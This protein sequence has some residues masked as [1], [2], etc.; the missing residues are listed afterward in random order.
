M[1]ENVM[2]FPN[3]AQLFSE[4]QRYL[5]GGVS[6]SMRAA[7]K[8]MPLFFSSG[9]GSRITDVDG[10]Q[11]IDYTL[12]WGPLILGHSH[13]AI[14]SAV[15]KQ[16]QL[17][18]TLGAQ[19]ELEILVAQ[20]ICEMVPCAELVAFNNSG[21]EAVQAA[22]RLARA[23]TGKR[24]II[25][26]EGHYHGWLDNIAAG[27]RLNPAEGLRE[28]ATQGSGNQYA[29]DTIILPW[30]DLQALEM[31]VQQQGNEIAA[32]IMEPILCNTSCLLPTSEYLRD[33]RK[34]ATQS[35]VVL[36][37]DEVI[38]GF[39]AALGGAQQ[40]FDVKPDLATFGKAVAGGFTLSVVAGR[41]DIMDLISQGKIMHAGTFNGNPIC[42]AAADATLN[43]LSAKQGAALQ[44]IRK[45]GDLLMNGIRSLAES[46]GVPL[47]INGISSSFHLSF[48]TRSKMQNF[49]DSLDADM[50]IRDQ[51]LEWMLLEGIY[52]MP[53]GRWYVSAAHTEEDVGRTLEA[54]DRVLSTRL[55]KLISPHS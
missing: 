22:F 3:S 33:A 44:H 18:Q 4:A 31:A 6:S 16:L 26:F 15:G 30:N 49:R 34:L 51:F 36:I 10:N 54:V 25:R 43:V 32:I 24:K 27:Y 50:S 28:S 53:D 2:R 55:A 39:R 41:W 7:A 23:F 8:P 48:T 37:F 5:A 1:T 35:G 29:A 21:T 40:L 46:S 17:C 47:L 38:T 11:Y 42:L 19:N 20:K 12:A 14:V 52:L 9:L 45:L 13:P